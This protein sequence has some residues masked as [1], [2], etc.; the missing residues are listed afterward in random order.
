MSSRV[1]E[2]NERKITIFGA[3]KGLGAHYI[4]L[5]KSVIHHCKGLGYT[6]QLLT[7]SKLHFDL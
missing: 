7:L 2:I 3:Q 1:Q 6:R 5:M 4:F